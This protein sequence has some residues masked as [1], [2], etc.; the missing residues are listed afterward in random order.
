M[1]LNATVNT[2]VFFIYILQTEYV[3]SSFTG[4]TIF[5]FVIKWTCKQNILLTPQQ[6]QLVR[7]RIERVLQYH[8]L[9]ALL[10]KYHQNFLTM[11]MILYCI[12][13]FFASYTIRVIYHRTRHQLMSLPCQLQEHIQELKDFSLDPVVS[14]YIFL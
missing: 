4:F 11:Q 1:C 10:W 6:M 9:L 12:Q 7:I 3:Q 8:G 13:F 5:M 2:G 14:G